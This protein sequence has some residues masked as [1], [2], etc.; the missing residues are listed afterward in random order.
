LNQER[1][2]SLSQQLTALNPSATL[3]RG[4]AIVR[5]L[6]DGQVVTRVEQAKTGNRLAVQV[7]NGTFEST[8][9]NTKQ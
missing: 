2:S 6:E 5:R 7:S 4:Y 9:Q 1:I 8:V 3:Q